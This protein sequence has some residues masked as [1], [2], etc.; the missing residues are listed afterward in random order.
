VNKRKDA[1]PGL[2]RFSYRV[3]PWRGVSAVP[4]GAGRLLPWHRAVHGAE[5]LDPE[6]FRVSVHATILAR[7]ALD[8]QTGL[9]IGNGPTEVE[10]VYRVDGEN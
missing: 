3:R 2:E 5:R 4:E 1:R 8:L 9:V 6:I 7:G 10:V